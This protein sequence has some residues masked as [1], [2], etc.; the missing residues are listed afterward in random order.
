MDINLLSIDFPFKTEKKSKKIERTS[1]D[2]NV[3]FQLISIYFNLMF[4]LN[5]KEI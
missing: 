2:I 3:L 4:L 5:Q 1:I